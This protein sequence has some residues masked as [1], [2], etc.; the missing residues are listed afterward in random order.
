MLVSTDVF[1]ILD[2]ESPL[3]VKFI[4]TMI[5]LE[6]LL[7]RGDSS[8]YLGWKLGERVAFLIG[9]DPVWMAK[10]YDKNPTEITKD[11][12]SKSLQGS[13]TE[14]DKSVR[15]LYNKRSGIAH[16]GL[17]SKGREITSEDFDK[18]SLILHLTLKKILEM[19][20]KSINLIA[21][22]EGKKS[23]VDLINNLKYSAAQ[24]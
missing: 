22:E 5:A 10:H 23:L 19:R 4:L 13:R 16:E 24:V 21:R 6:S 8:D 18:A 9:D 17:T 12:I 11:Y 14:L 1:G 15:D 20:K 7:T 2:S 3:H